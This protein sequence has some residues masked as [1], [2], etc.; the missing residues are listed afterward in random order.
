MVTGAINPQNEK[1]LGVLTLTIRAESELIPAQLYVALIVRDTPVDVGPQFFIGMA[2]LPKITPF[3]AAYNIN[4]GTA[5]VDKLYN[6]WN[7]EGSTEIAHA[8]LNRL[9]HLIRETFNLISS[10]IN[11][12]NAYPHETVWKA[13]MHA[14]L[15]E[16][17]DKMGYALTL[18]GVALP[19]I[20]HHEASTPVPSMLL[21]RYEHLRLRFRGIMD[22][23]RTLVLPEQ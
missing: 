22:E 4:Y 10:I 21:E 23:A 2:Q 12:V 5:I 3:I 14:S 1:V 16:I 13:H 6:Q 20:V 11:D 17:K 9:H 7:K 18:L 15:V 19:R 8:T